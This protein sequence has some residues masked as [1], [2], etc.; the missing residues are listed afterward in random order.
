MK[1]ESFLAV[2]KGCLFKSARRGVEVMSIV[3]VHRGSHIS[4]QYPQV[5]KGLK[6]I[7]IPTNSEVA[8][9]CQNKLLKW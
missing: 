6:L 1:R 4:I 9:D 7:L 3:V 8:N 5:E 2:V